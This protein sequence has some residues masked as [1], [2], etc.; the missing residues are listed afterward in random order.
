V[1]PTVAALALTAAMVADATGGRLS[2]GRPD[3]AF[4]GVS[5]DSRTI[6]PGALFIAIRG[7]R[8]DGHAFVPAA[9]ARGASGVLVAEPPA[10][11]APV[12]VIE[13][14]DTLRALQDLGRA[15]RRASGAKVVAVT[16]SAGKTTTKE[17]TAELLAARYR[18]FR[19]TGNLNNH[20]GLPLSLVGLRE[21]PDVA[22]VEFGMNHPGELR[23]LVG[24]AEPDVRVW[25]NV[26]DAHVGFFG[27]RAA[28]A[29][30]KAEI[31]E[32]ATAETLVVANADDPL[33]MAHVTR[34]A[35]RRV[36]FGESAGAD[37]RATAVVDRGFD[38]TAADVVTREGTWSIQVPLPGRVQLLNVLAAAA[39]A[40][41]LGITPA[42]IAARTATL[43]PVARRGRTTRRADG[44]R[45][46]DD[47]YNAS[48]AAAEAMLTALAATPTA[49]RRVAVLGEMLELGEA[50]RDLHEAVGR[51]AARAGV[52]MLVAI[53]GPAADGLAAGAIAGGLPGSHIYRFRDSADAAG[54]V[55]RLVAA[56]D[57]VL[58]KGSRGSRTDL[59][60]DRLAEAG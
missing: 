20:I 44:A 51:A 15:V 57:L 38:G 14:A 36:T 19:N 3:Q 9:I 21:G 53:G 47:S 58:V 46:V 12:A 28:V 27:S 16:G 54:P 8:F 35:G 48:P 30:A 25:T 56:G 43:A 23:T 59:V 31:L 34:F 55:T 41:E 17:A 18:V 13:V 49:G 42:E 22:V 39:V 52:Q 4:D 7:D 60:A 11:A 32:Q 45:I 5:I 1:T 33:V 26:G 6:Q 37:V 2:A 40:L 29:E 24:I 10:A 50:A